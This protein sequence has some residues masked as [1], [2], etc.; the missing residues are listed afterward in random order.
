MKKVSVFKGRNS[1]N[2][3]ITFVAL[4]IKK[5]Y[6]N[7]AR[8]PDSIKVL[9][10]ADFAKIYKGIPVEELTAKPQQIMANENG[11]TLY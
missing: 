8:Y 6:D 3:T 2:I 4:G 1:L 9:T 11:W 5:A 7:P 10:L